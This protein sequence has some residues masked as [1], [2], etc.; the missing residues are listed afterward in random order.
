MGFDL[1]I[2]IGTLGAFFSSPIALLGLNPIWQR[3]N[4]QPFVDF[5]VLPITASSWAGWPRRPAPVGLDDRF[6]GSPRLIGYGGA[7]ALAKAGRY[8]PG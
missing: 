4:G 3:L 6:L 7:A 8:L 1:V 2:V 5:A